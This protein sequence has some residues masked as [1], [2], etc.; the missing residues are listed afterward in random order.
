LANTTSTSS[1]F[2]VK[3]LVVLLICYK[4]LKITITP[5]ANNTPFVYQCC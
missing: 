4:K 1:S 3:A 5:T 2:F